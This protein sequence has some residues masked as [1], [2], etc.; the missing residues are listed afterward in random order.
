MQA[1]RQEDIANGIQNNIKNHNFT[2][3]VAKNLDIIRYTEAVST[4]S[5]SQLHDPD[6]LNN[7]LSHLAS[8]KEKLLDSGTHLGGLVEIYQN[9]EL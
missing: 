1:N 5:T 8:R 4:H 9:N 3:I 6:Q 7:K 2:K